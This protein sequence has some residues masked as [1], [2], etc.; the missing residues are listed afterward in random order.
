MITGCN[1]V[2]VVMEFNAADSLKAC[3]IGGGHYTAE[4][5][6]GNLKSGYGVGQLI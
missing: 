4:K 6:E 5:E 1:C 3:F 2:L